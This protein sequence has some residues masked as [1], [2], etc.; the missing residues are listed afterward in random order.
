MISALFILNL[1]G[2]VLISRLYRPDVK[3]SIADIF[4][5]RVISNPDVRSPII[6][7]GST[8]FFHVR[9][10]NSYLAAVTKTNA[11]AVIVFE[12]LY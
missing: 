12:F 6:T 2:E 10:Q 1:K 3:R 8:S 7:L 11:N 5:I 9:H 4:Q